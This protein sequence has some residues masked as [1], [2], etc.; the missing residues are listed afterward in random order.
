MALVT[1]KAVAFGAAA[2]AAILLLFR[3]KKASAAPSEPEPIPVP[4]VPGPGP[5]PPVYDCPPVTSGEM[6]TAQAKLNVVGVGPLVVDGV[7]GPKTRAALLKFQKGQGLP[8]SG[9]L[10][11]ATWEALKP[12]VIPSAPPASVEYMDKNGLMW[13]IDNPST[14]VFRGIYRDTP[15]AEYGGI[16]SVIVQDSLSNAKLAIDLYSESHPV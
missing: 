4:P 15:I 8:E 10:D 6:A 1:G 3:S 16:P 13:E 9:C 11:A 2:L 14:G 7:Y 12:Y 5:V